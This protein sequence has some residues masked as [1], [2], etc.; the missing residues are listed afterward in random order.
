MQLT[1]KENMLKVTKQQAIQ[2]FGNQSK[3]A[4][5]LGVSRAAIS[6]WPDELDQARQDRVIGAAKRLGVRIPKQAKP[7]VAA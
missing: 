1:N 7:S 3:L 6:Q 4:V 5:A 2:A